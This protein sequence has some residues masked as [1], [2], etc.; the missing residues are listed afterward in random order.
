M[1]KEKTMMYNTYI[2]A[3]ERIDYTYI[4][5][6]ERIDYTYIPIDE[7]ISRVVTHFLSLRNFLLYPLGERSFFDVQ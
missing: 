7:L 2:P 3:G 1:G 6:G 5:A 4:P